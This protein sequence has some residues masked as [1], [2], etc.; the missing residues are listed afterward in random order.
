VE[1]LRE[2]IPV[3]LASQEVFIENIEQGT[4]RCAGCLSVKDMSQYHVENAP[5]FRSLL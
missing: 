2:K 5:R 4:S 1:N 3:S